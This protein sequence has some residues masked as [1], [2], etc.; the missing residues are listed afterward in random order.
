[1]A[2]WPTCGQSGYITPAVLG[3]PKAAQENRKQ[4]WLPD[5]HV[6]KVANSPL[7]TWGSP[8]L[9][10]GTKD[11][12]GYPA[13]LWARWLHHLCRLGGSQRSAREQKT[14]MATRLTCGQG[15]YITSAVW[16]GPNAQRGNKRRKWLPGSL[17]G[18]VA[19]SPLP[20]G[21]VPTLSAGT[22]DGN[23]YPAHLWARWLHH[24]C[25][26]GG[27]QRSARGR[28]LEMAT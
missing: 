3:V 26:L 18:K 28:N 15:G 9:S 11:G 16:G 19:T 7:P 1:M 22:K 20:S 10:A 23:G 21:G 24:L 13:H 27:S 12:N 17:V 4:K 2:T 25:R 8:M 14:E 5:P 6:A